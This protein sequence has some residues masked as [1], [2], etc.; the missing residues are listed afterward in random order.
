ML[1][2]LLK[3]LVDRFIEF[4]LHITQGDSPEARL[5]SVLKSTVFLIS[6]LVFALI[7]LVVDNFN[8]R[9]QLKDYESVASKVGFLLNPENASS[10]ADELNKL[11]TS[12][13]TN[14]NTLRKENAELSE[15]NISLVH[16]NYWLQVLLKK[17]MAEMKRLKDNN[18]ALLLKQKHP[19][20][21]P[22]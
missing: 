17:Q 4:L 13:D 10:T 21:K 16:E 18:D 2:T 12:I 6:V 1:F 7:S 22:N 19:P 3:E 11:S 14:S 20:P 8:L 15:S 5:T 9:F